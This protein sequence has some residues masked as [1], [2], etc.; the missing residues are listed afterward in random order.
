M[1]NPKSHLH[2]PQYSYF[3][4]SYDIPGTDNWQ[5]TGHSRALERTGFW[6]PQLGIVLD[7]GV[8]LPTNAGCQPKA[9]LITHG[10]IDHCNAL[11]MLLRH[12]SS[13][14]SPTHILAP[15]NIVHRL[16]SYAQL[17]WA[18][19]VDID[20]PLP[21]RYAPPPESER[22]PPAGTALAPEGDL[23][24]RVWRPCDHSTSLT[25]QVGKKNKTSVQIQCLQLF[26]KECSTIGY[27]LSIPAHTVKKVRPDLVGATKQETGKNVQ[28]A[29]ARGEDIQVLVQEPERAKLAFVLDTTIEALMESESNTARSIL[30]CPVII[31]ECTYLEES[32]IGEARK[33][34]HICWHE[35]LPFVAKSVHR[36]RQLATGFQQ[37]WI[38]VHFSLRYMDEQIL[39][40]FEDETQ[41]K[42][43]LEPP[44]PPTAA[45][46][47]SNKQRSPPDIVLW[48]DDGPMKLWIDFVNI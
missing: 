42:L 40:F 18:V 12:H 27:L 30:Q 32:M 13:E 19:K 1:F 15:A 10:H 41:S 22:S 25:L 24:F 5:M 38:L 36:R 35:L 17:S 39:Q 26:H 33:R 29:R 48:L 11:P 7:A 9:I 28:A 34:G 20:S 47:K 45:D 6:I 43:H 21:D 37:T 8:D 16:R 4:A 14:E 3:R 31:I 2:V 46:D 44:P 23:P